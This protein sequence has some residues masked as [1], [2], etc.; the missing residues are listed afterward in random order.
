MGR[1]RGELVSIALRQARRQGLSGPGTKVFLVGDHLNDIRAARENGIPVISVTT[2]PMR[3]EEL[4]A[5]APDY[6]VDS[7]EQLPSE[8]IFN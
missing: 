4:S 3:R 5:F 1:T 7:L 8:I 6:L 2:G